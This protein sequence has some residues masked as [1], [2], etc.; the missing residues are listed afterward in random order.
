MCQWI[1]KVRKAW[2]TYSISNTFNFLKQNL[3]DKVPPPPLMVKIL[4]N[5]MNANKQ[6]LCE[7]DTSK[8]DLCIFSDK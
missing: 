8:S 7:Y 2:G 6:F 4:M 3:L 1:Q 5:R